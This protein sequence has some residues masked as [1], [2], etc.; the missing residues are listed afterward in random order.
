MRLALWLKLTLAFAA[1]AI[2]G[3]VVAAFL[4]DR[5]TATEFARYLRHSWGMGQMMGSGMGA[6]MGAAEQDFLNSV[7][8]ALWIAGGVAV[9]LA[10]IVAIFLSR[11]VTAPLRRLS[12][13]ARQVAQGDLSSRVTAS[14]GDE[15]GSLA[16]T[17]NSMVESLQHGQE[18]RRNLMAD[19]AHEMSTPLA[20]MQSNLEAMLDGLVEPSQSNISSLHEEA[21]LLSRLVKDLRTLSLAESGRLELHLAPSDLGAVVTSVVTA[22]EAEA[23]R[24]D[25]SL[26]LQVTPGLP[27]AMMDSNRVS[28]VVVNLLANALRYTSEGG[29]VRV[30]VGHHTT[31][32]TGN[33]GLLVSVAD[34]GQ[35][36]AKEDLSRIFDRYY[37]GSQSRDRRAGGSGIGLAVVKELVEAHKGRVWVES[38][39]GKGSTFF[40]TLPAAP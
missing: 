31:G 17:F 4:I 21:M 13:A 20:V 22:T 11:Q 19:L 23:K 36:I 16:T 35:G 18:M 10:A 25:I 1:I 7:R 38:V 6:M 28:Q 14:S 30:N 33:A 34:T 9:A 24:K 15:V 37:Q 8:N 32:G 29:S 3:V 39:P 27:Q 12:A 40:F 5:A 2:L 26:S